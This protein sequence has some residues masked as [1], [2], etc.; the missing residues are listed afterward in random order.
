MLVPSV[1]V[2]GHFK[3][4]KVIQKHFRGVAFVSVRLGKVPVV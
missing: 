2:P 1:A 3:K 4:T